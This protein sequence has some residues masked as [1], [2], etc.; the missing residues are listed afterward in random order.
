MADVGVDAATVN[1]CLLEGSDGGERLSEGS[2]SPESSTGHARAPYTYQL[3]TPPAGTAQDWLQ[4]LLDR[5][6]GSGASTGCFRSDSSDSA[7][8]DASL[9]VS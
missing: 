8:D 5:Q 2:P 6:Q 9:Y 1:E 3:T 4:H 7:E